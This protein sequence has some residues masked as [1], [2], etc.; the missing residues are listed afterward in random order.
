M[1]IPM[2]TNAAA[3]DP[4]DDTLPAPT[5]TSVEFDDVVDDMLYA[6][7]RGIAER[8]MRELRG[9]H[10]TLSPTALVHEAYLKLGNGAKTRWRDR[11]HFLSAAAVAMR[12]I[13]V[14]RAR[15][16]VA[17]KRSGGGMQITLEEQLAVAG[18]AQS[19]LLEIDDALNR[20]QVVAPR[21]AR[22][23]VLRFYGGMSDSEIADAMG[24]TRRTVQRDWMKARMLLSRALQP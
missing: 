7:L 14:D 15:A 12:H 18:D 11:T 1:A 23:V 24:V 10:T 3:R 8:R 6:E 9:S 21:L 22:L 13:L 4:A 5:I 20:L 17:L 2:H 16:R 19:S